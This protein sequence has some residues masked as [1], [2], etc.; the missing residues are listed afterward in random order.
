LRLDL[1]NTLLLL[2][3]L[4]SSRYSPEPSAP[5]EPQAGPSSSSAPAAP[6]PSAPSL[7]QRTNSGSAHG[8]DPLA[9][10]GGAASPRYPPVFDT[11]ERKPL[12]S[13]EDAAPAATSN[14][15]AASADHVEPSAPPPM[16]ERGPEFGPVYLPCGH[17]LCGRCLSRWMDTQPQ[18]HPT[19]PVCRKPVIP[20]G[21]QQPPPPPQQQPRQPFPE[22]QRR[23]HHHGY[24]WRRHRWYNDY[25]SPFPPSAC[26]GTQDVY[27]PELLFRLRQLQQRYPAAIDAN[28]QARWADAAAAGQPIAPAAEVGQALQNLELQERLQAAQR[29][30]SAGRNGGSGS[31]NF[32][33]GSSRG[34]GGR[35]G[36]W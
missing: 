12:L 11:E 19:C 26:A 5:L 2:F 14:P 25:F 9:S 10:A 36:G 18:D 29:G 8:L 34:G 31:W 7:R 1:L 17:S 24:H 22:Q 6:G 4:L 13:T 28:A 15:A 20:G 30:N 16:E 23:H 33:G 3:N 27:L 21:A 32:G 35:G